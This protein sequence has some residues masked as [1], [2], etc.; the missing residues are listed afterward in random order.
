MD[1]IVKK[2]ANLPASLVT[3]IGEGLARGF[4]GQTSSAR[5]HTILKLDRA[6]AGWMFGQANTPV[7]QGSRW[8]V[9]T[10]TLKH[11]LV[12]WHD[13]KVVYENMVD[14]WVEAPAIPATVH[15]TGK[16]FQMQR[17]VEM[18]CL[19]GEDEGQEVL[20][21]IS[22]DGGNERLGEL[23]KF[24]GVRIAQY[25]HTHQYL[26]PVIELEYESYPNK[27]HGGRTYKPILKLVGWSDYEG[28]I[29]R[30]PDG[31]TLEIVRSNGNVSISWTVGGTLQSADEIIGPWS[32]VT[33]V[34]SPF[35]V[36]TPGA[37]RKFYRLRQAP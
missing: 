19:D 14:G 29:G 18:R 37:G 20:Y 3:Q 22:S 28:E 26:Y 16:P 27:T 23:G 11:G 13:S 31:P 8:R 9:D 24:A 32:D 21:K 12:V 15:P 36:P 5:G 2:T 1:D 6:G 17:S 10:G 33:G 30:P 25:A 35:P 7:Q 34:S 4:A